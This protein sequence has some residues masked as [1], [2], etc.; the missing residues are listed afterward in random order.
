[1]EMDGTEE[2]PT[3]SAIV[4]S[5]KLAQKA[6]LLL[7][8]LKCLRTD[9]QD[10]MFD[11]QKAL[12]HLSWTTPVY[13]RFSRIMALLN[14]SFNNAEMAD[15]KIL[16][17]PRKGTFSFIYAQFWK[18]LDFDVNMSSL[19]VNDLQDLTLTAFIEKMW[20]LAAS[21]TMLDDTL[22]CFLSFELD[23]IGF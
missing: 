19:T 16:A 18:T 15:T 7:A 23:N 2:E 12:C 17:L 9:E 4:A 22:R 20:R 6:E 11:S 3:S 1:M 8:S 21:G 10:S 5:L 13:E 14:T